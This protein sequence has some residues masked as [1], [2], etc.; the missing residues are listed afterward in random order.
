[1]YEGPDA[2]TVAISDG[3]LTIWVPVTVMVSAVNDAPVA[4]DVQAST[5]ENQAVAIVLAVTDV[6]STALSY[7][8]VTAPAHGGLTGAF[9][10]LVYMP[11]FRYHG[12]DSFS[13]RATDSALSSN[14][15]IVTVAVANVVTCGDSVV[16]SAEQCDDGNDDNTDDCL[17][18]CAAARCG[19]G[20]VHT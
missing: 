10:N 15:A 12:D 7:V 11:D 2:F 14:V 5:N 1:N 18:N 6:D 17:D 3:T 19:D 4:G 8:V 16:E 20:V 9:P 13:Y